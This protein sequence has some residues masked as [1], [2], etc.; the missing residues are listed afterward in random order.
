MSS[1]SSAIRPMASNM[2]FTSSLTRQMCKSCRPSRRTFASPSR[3][4]S[5]I[6]GLLQQQRHTSKLQSMIFT[7]TNKRFASSSS[8]SPSA[9]A[10]FPSRNPSS[11]STSKQQ[12]GQKAY[13]AKRNKSLLLYTAGVLVLGVGVTY[14]AVPLYRI[15]CSACVSALVH[16]FL[17]KDGG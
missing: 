12:A 10:S 17:Y 7:T 5:E 11:S 16:T 14:A 13:Y 3:N 8:S 1:L 4:T 15:F 6:A 9:S 2:V